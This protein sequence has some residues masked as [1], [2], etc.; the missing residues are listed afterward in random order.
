MI[1]IILLAILAVAA[2]ATMDEIKQHWTRIFA[3]W[4]SPEKKITKWFNPA[5]S[6]ENKYWTHNKYLDWVFM[7]PLV[8]V[9]DFWHFLKFIMLN[10]IYGIIILL[11]EVDI[12]WYWLIIGMNFAWGVLFE[13]TTGIYGVFADRKKFVN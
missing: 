2:N 13:F 12:H 1:W 10:S 9:T 3:Y 6:W 7:S 8:F 5:I 4:F 11:I